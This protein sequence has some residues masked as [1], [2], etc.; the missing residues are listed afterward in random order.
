MLEHALAETRAE[1]ARERAA[2]ATA[3]Q[4]GLA[5]LEAAMAAELGALAQAIAAR[6]IGTLPDAVDAALLAMANALGSQA[7]EG[8]VL[9]AHPAVAPRLL[10]LVA[11]AGM[12]VEADPALSEGMVAAGIGGA[13][14]VDSLPMRLAQVAAAVVEQP[15]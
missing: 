3:M 10:T 13:E 7:G 9:R 6:V 15:A 4:Q 14:R 8:A 2:L 5:A 1:A 11:G 12:R